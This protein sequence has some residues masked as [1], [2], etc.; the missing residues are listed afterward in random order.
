MNKV[1]LAGA[2]AQRTGMLKVDAESVTD[3]LFRII[4]DTLAA[5]DKVRVDSFGTFEVKER[6]ARV[7][8][9]PRANVPVDIPAR[10]APSFSAH[11]TLKEAVDCGK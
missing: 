8:R 3:A 2:L 7:G 4:A 1:E 6:A 11:K 10:R 5:G 9:N